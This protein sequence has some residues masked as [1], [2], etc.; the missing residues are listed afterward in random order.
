MRVLASSIVGAAAITQT[1]AAFGT[2]VT[3]SSNKIGISTNLIKS[4]TGSSIIASTPFHHGRSDRKN[5]ICRNASK[6]GNIE[7]PKNE[8]SR[9]YRTEIILGPRRR[10]YSTSIS[11]EPEEREALAER[12]SLSEISRLEADLV[13]KRESSRRGGGGGG[14]GGECIQVSGS[15]AAAVKQTCVRTN[16]DF[17]V[18]LEFNLF[19]AVRSTASREDENL[20]LGGMD[21][22][23]IEGALG[24]GR[25]SGSK[26]SKNKKRG[27]RRDG[28][29]MRGQQLNE[30]GMKEIEDLLQDFDMEEDV[31][32]DDAV[33]GADGV[34]D[35]G[36]LV[37]QFFRL[38]L[39]PYPKKPGSSPVNYSIT[40]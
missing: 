33:L 29:G 2:G 13:L 7:R 40:G 25:G 37:A 9:P 36:E 5:L 19:A 16:E 21:L 1:A 30:M 23:Q 20:K 12:F 24:G 26:K 10:E 18:E 35:A 3:T 34:L 39:D 4:G 31:V 27:G 22:A 28:R 17:D 38:K 14:G 6:T 32:E 8:F 11:A 15:V